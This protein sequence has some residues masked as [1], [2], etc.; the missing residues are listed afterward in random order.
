MRGVVNG[1]NF[2]PRPVVA[3]SQVSIFGDGFGNSPKVAVNGKA[4]AV[5]YGGP[6]QI[7]VSLP[8]NVNIG[9]N[10]LTVTANGTAGPETNFWVTEAMP[11]VFAN[12]EGR[13]IAVNVDG[14]TLNGVDSPVRAG[15]PLTLYLTGVG[16]VTSDGLHDATYPW[17]ATV[18]GK[19]AGKLFL[20]LAP[21]FVGVYQANIVIP[22]DLLTG[23]Y[24]LA[25]TVN[26]VVSR[27]AIITVGN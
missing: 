10:H 25:F 11:A 3:G 23:D 18:G 5:E 22:A 20:G 9:T 17:T 4:V 7:N 16:A 12:T 26:G 6:T 2:D 14:N 21:L 19:L 27:E 24:S 13:A 1:A 15:R 8:S